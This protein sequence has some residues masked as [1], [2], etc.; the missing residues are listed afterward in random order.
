MNLTPDDREQKTLEDLWRDQ[1]PVAGPTVDLASPQLSRRSPSTPPAAAGDLARAYGRLIGWDGWVTLYPKPP[2]AIMAASR[3]AAAAGLPSG[4]SWMAPGCG[5]PLEPAGSAP[6]V[7]VL[8]ADWAPHAATVQAAAEHVRETGW[9]LVMDESATGFRLAQRGAAQFYGVTP[10]LVL[11]APA[12]TAKRSMA[13]LAGRGEPPAQPKGETRPELLAAAAD[14]LDW[15]GRRDLAGHL[16]ALGRS[17]LVGL[18]WACR[19]VGLTDEVRHNGP[20]ALPRLEGRRFWAFAELAREEG[21]VLAPLTCLEPELSIEDMEKLVWPR[22]LR[23]AARL[24][25]LPEGDMAPLGWK[26]ASLTSCSR[27]SDILK[28]I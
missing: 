22:L 2:Q 7:A 16:A 15:L 3:L 27:V 24:K 17:F 21:L 11:W 28:T 1:A 23:A 20:A 4:V 25:A 18:D 5:A 26:D 12:L 10:D 8:R 9:L 6:G 19:R 14:L 13:W